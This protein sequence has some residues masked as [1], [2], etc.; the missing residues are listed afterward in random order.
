MLL[1][2]LKKLSL[3]NQVCAFCGK[4]LKQ[5]PQK[6]RF[7]DIIKE[8]ELYKT[9]GNVLVSACSTCFSW[10]YTLTN[11]EF[12]TYVQE[13]LQQ[14]G[15]LFKRSLG[16]AFAYGNDENIVFFYEIVNNKKQNGNLT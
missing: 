9:E 1:H 15:L 6:C 3:I 2:Q 5:H 16:P 13:T 12:R 10:R 7:Y 11:E 4:K 8:K 14:Q